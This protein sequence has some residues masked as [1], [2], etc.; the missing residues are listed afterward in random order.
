MSA[1][2]GLLNRAINALPFELHI[3]GYQFCG[4]RTHLEKRLARGD[5][6]INL[7]DA[8]CR[9]HDI[10]YSRNKDLAKR[11]IADKV[12]AEKEQKRITAKDS[13]LGERAAAAAGWAAMKA[14]TKIGMD[15]KPKKTTTTT[16]TTTRKK[17]TKRMRQRRNEAARYQF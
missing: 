8:A 15:M 14:K 3:P 17:V 9:E 10:A 11:H 5:A 16:T 6:G 13:T 1:L 2:C 7:L 12:L 4:P